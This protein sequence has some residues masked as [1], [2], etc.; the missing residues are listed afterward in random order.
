MIASIKPSGALALLV[1]GQFG[2][3]VDY[4]NNRPAAMTSLGPA[5]EWKV[6]APLNLQLTHSYERLS[7]PAGWLYTANLLQFR[8]VFHFNRQT[9]VRAIL[10]YTDVSRDPSLYL[11]PTPAKSSKLFSQFLFSYK[12]NPQTVLLAG[13]SDNYAGGARLALA[14]TNRTLFVKVGYA[15]LL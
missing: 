6:G 10:Q 2:D 7:V 3:A 12:L 4:A 8:A 14:Q 5:I 11:E 9:F 1:S 13:Y 15:W